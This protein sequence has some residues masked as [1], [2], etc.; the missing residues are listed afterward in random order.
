[1]IMALKI[2]GGYSHTTFKNASIS[3]YHHLGRHPKLEEE[4]RI[5]SPS[6]ETKD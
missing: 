6:R 1:M 2:L 3:S 4:D 5:E